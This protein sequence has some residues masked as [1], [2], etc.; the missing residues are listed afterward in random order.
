MGSL[1]SKFHDKM[2][3]IADF[4]GGLLWIL[5]DALIFKGLAQA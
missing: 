3:R 1:L 5:R 2:E 4:A